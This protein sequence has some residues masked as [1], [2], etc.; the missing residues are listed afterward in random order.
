MS[1]SV[2]NRC[3]E[4]P[5]GATQRGSGFCAH[6]IACSASE[7]QARGDQQRDAIRGRRRG[8]SVE[9]LGDV[10]PHLLALALG[11]RPGVLA[12]RRACRV[13]GARG[14]LGLGARDR[15][16]CSLGPRRARQRPRAGPRRG[17][18]SGPSRRRPGRR[19]P[20]SPRRCEPRPRA[21]R[22]PPARGTRPSTAAPGRR[23]NSRGCA[24]S[25]A[26]A[27]A[28]AARS[29]DRW[30]SERPPIPRATAPSTKAPISRPQSPPRISSAAWPRS[31]LTPAPT[32]GGRRPSVAARRASQPDGGSSRAA[33]GPS[34]A[35]DASARSA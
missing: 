12:A 18:G 15:P 31:P 14:E 7:R 22:P 5:G 19:R 30:A 4:V 1:S 33:G 2:P 25:I 10:G 11:E 35:S 17:S 29:A 9:R 3:S 20:P 6:R 34:A 13:Q 8:E 23:V 28:S 16:R 24:S 27:P 26:R 32:T 21:P